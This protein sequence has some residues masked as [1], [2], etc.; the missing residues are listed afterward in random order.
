MQW[1]LYGPVSSET[2]KIRACHRAPSRVSP[3]QQSRDMG[4][5][6]TWTQE[7][8]VPWKALSLELKDVDFSSTTPCDCVCGPWG[9]FFFFAFLV[10]LSSSVG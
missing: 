7:I 5:C 6:D 3:D 9:D 8:S 2:V 4:D 10:P 1:Q